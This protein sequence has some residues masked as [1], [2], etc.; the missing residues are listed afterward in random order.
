[1]SRRDRHWWLKVIIG[2]MFMLLVGEVLALTYAVIPLARSQQKRA[3]PVA[4]S[5]RLTQS[6][7]DQALILPSRVPGKPWVTRTPLPTATPWLIPTAKPQPAGNATQRP[8]DTPGAST[9]LESGVGVSSAVPPPLVAAISPV[10]T[11][12]LTLSSSQAVG[13]TGTIGPT[14]SPSEDVRS[15]GMP[16]TAQASPAKTVLADTPT[17]EEILPTETLDA[18]SS[19]PSPTRSQVTDQ[20]PPSIVPGDEAQFKVY[21]ME[22][23]G[24][25]AGQA[26][27][28]AAV[29]LDTTAPGALG[30]MVELSGDGANNVFA[31]QP[32]AAVLDYGHRLLNDM[33]S[34]SS[35]EYYALTVASTYD[36]SS[37]DDCINN[38]TWCDLDTFDAS[39]NTWTVTWTY[40]RG[41]SVDGMDSVDTRNAGQ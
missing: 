20:P 12:R 24:A 38:P 35:D 26:L 41:T 14:P 4:S 6:P 11:P 36:T 17:P 32:V 8:V 39:A 1:M 23:Y 10:A 40:L 22:Q 16:G 21:V 5:A 34:Y 25:I 13:P 19:T 9:A 31:A 29:T 7:A 2:L 33:K 18:P 30:M 27:D 15:A 37:G 28:I 3:E